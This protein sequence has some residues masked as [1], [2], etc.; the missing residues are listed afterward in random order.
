MP[1]RTYAPQLPEANIVYLQTPLFF[2]ANH[3]FRIMR[4]SIDIVAKLISPDA[5]SVSGRVLSGVSL[6]DS[7]LQSHSLLQ[8]RFIRCGFKG[9]TFKDCTFNHSRFSD[10]YFRKANFHRVSFI[11]CEFR[12]CKFDEAVF[13]NCQ[14]DHAE[15]SN[16]SITYKQVLSSLPRYENVLWRLARNLRVNAQNRGEADESRAFLLVELHAS[17]RY[18]YRKAFDWDDRYYGH[19]Y[20]PLER[21][22]AL[23]E[24]SASKIGHVLWGHGER[25]I[26]VLRMSLLIILGFAVLYIWKGVFSNFPPS[27][28]WLEDLGY[29]FAAFAS[30]SYGNIAPAN[31][32][33]RFMSAVESVLGL[34][35]FGFFVSALYRRISKR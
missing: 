18:N 10:C 8:C 22:S 25:P 11:G 26:Y 24:W 23:K 17:E 32:L 14:L 30:A 20:K 34:V 6:N 16:C 28:V 27:Y 3:T 19:K 5:V 1:L 35:L 31:G 21:V 4:N 9:T 13:D 2:Q 15:F 12:N 7:S 29:S 33:T